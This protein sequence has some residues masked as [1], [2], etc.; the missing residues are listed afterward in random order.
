MASQI[1][2]VRHEVERGLNGEVVEH[3]LCKPM[4]ADARSAAITTAEI[5]GQIWETTISVA[6]TWSK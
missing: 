4:T 6:T 3:R 2:V 5:D 1:S